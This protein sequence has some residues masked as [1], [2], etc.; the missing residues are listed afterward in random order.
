MTAHVESAPASDSGEQAARPPATAHTAP[1]TPSTAGDSPRRVI[2]VITEDH[3]VASPQGVFT[4]F[5]LD[6][7]YWTQYLRI[8]DE[9]RPLARVQTVESADPSW[10]RS[11]GPRVN[12]AP[13]PFYQ[14]IA[15]LAK[16][17]SRVRRAVRDGLCC[18]APESD[19]TRYYY[20]MRGSGPLCVL[21]WRALRS[22]GR[23]FAR[24]IVGHDREGVHMGTNLRPAFLRDW[25]ARG[26]YSVSRRMVREASAVAY[27]S[28]HLR[29][30]YPENPGTPVFFFSDV[31]LNAALITRPRRADEFAADTLRIVSVGRM[32]PEK[33]YDV[34]LDAVERLLAEGEARWTLEVIGVGPQLDGLRARVATGPLA[35]RVRFS[36][37]VP[38]GPELYQ[39][40]DAADLYVLP[41]LTEG[42]PRALLE[43]M[44]RGLPALASNV[45]GVP[46]LVHP[47]ALLPAGDAGA[48]AAA[49]RGLIGRRDEL[50]RRSSAGFE[51]AMRFHPDV[52]H[53]RKREYW[54]ALR[55]ITDRRR[56]PAVQRR[57]SA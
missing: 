14:G 6:Y 29:E 47:D 44:A 15:S 42:T 4:R 52:M 50:S 30:A 7:D 56:A 57:G 12:F 40:L 46:A 21:A 51:L 23:P 22:R 18:D 41:S 2:V 55:E 8:F 27:V 35:R 48:W 54:T 53:A 9:V 10:R 38:L 49:L 36:G 34:L 19:N 17:L 28:A 33:G 5:G 3:Y 25:I 13:I 32:N 39:R 31:N 37:W 1:H 20:A 16:S 26:L 11:D 45:G 24:Q 43:A